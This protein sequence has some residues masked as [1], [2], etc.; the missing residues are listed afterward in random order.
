M[1]NVESSGENTQVYIKRSRTPPKD[2]VPRKDLPLVT[3]TA[4]QHDNVPPSH[5]THSEPGESKEAESHQDQEEEKFQE[6]ELYSAKAEIERVLQYPLVT[7]ED[8][9]IGN[10]EDIP[11]QRHEMLVRT[12]S[13]VQDK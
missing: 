7:Y 6:T 12:P 9:S 4:E 10:E 11:P 2:S 5:R 8:S 13:P 3:P 1:I